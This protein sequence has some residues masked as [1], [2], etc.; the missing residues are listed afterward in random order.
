M[1]RKGETCREISKV[2]IYIHTYMNTIGICIYT[3]RRDTGER[4]EEP[5]DVEEEFPFRM[6]LGSDSTD[7][8]SEWR[9]TFYT[10]RGLFTSTSSVCLFV[11]L[12][13]FPYLSLC[14]HE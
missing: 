14:V 3:P 5:E 11:C 6:Q 13:A 12:S 8:A 7:A 10:E 4:K 1:G 2:H 9:E